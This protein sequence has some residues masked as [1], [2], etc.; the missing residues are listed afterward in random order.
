MWYSLVRRV[1]MGN[2]VP[3]TSV[4]DLVESI[5][6]YFRVFVGVMGQQRLCRDHPINLK[7]RCIFGNPVS[8]KSKAKKLDLESVLFLIYVAYIIYIC[9]S[10]TKDQK[11]S[12]NHVLT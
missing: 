5:K 1:G 3:N 8:P 9:G 10:S 6:Q 7:V 2:Q 11:G 12:R 4:R